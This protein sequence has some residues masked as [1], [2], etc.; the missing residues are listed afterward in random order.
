MW[1]AQDLDPVGN[2]VSHVFMPRI[3]GS[4]RVEMGTSQGGVDAQHCLSS[5]LDSR[6]P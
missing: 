3:P 5:N 2:R 4:S 6:E 1:L